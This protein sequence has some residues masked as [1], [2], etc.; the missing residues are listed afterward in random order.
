MKS[1]TSPLQRKRL[2]SAKSNKTNSVKFSKEYTVASKI[3]P[4]PKKSLA[5][6]DY[7]GM[8]LSPKSK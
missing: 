2:N 7:S 6:L 1:G 5:N 8:L 3:Q 4:Y